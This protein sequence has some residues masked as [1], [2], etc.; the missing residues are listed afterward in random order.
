VEI[1]TLSEMEN[2]VYIGNLTVPNDLGS[3]DELRKVIFNNLGGDLNKKN[4]QDENG[5]H[6]V[7]KMEP[8]K[9]NVENDDA[10]EGLVRNEN[11]FEEKSS[12][13]VE[14]E[15]S[16][17]LF[18]KIDIGENTNTNNNIDKMDT[19]EIK[20]EFMVIKPEVVPDEENSENSFEED[21]GYHFL[22]QLQQAFGGVDQ[23]DISLSKESCIQEDF[24]PDMTE[25]EMYECP[26]CSYS[27]TY[28][29]SVKR[30]IYIH[31]PEIDSQLPLGQR[32]SCNLC[33]KR[34]YDPRHLQKH[35]KSIHGF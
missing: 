20:L 16:K 23:Q 8:P 22:T 2:L 19:E 35:L 27:K 18:D 21:I 24:D 17:Y 30:H 3:F 4:D 31:H 34:Y 15:R 11:K 7:E 32:L 10:E 28:H 26:N 12:N 25:P 33:E 29:L 5:I 9:K 1:D 14:H 6:H 13:D